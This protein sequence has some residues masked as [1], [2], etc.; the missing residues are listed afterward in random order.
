MCFL[1]P[2]IAAHATT[3]WTPAHQAKRVQQYPKQLPASLPVAH[4]R[5]CTPQW[6]L[7]VCH[8]GPQRRAL[9]RART[10][11][12][13][14]VHVTHANCEQTKHGQCT[15]VRA[16]THTHRSK[17]LLEVSCSALRHMYDK[18]HA[19]HVGGCN[20]RQGAGSK[21]RGL[22]AHTSTMLLLLLYTC[23]QRCCSPNEGHWGDSGI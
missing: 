8:R 18:S 5:V 22:T 4:T 17:L 11:S 21:Q 1:P 12:Q 19:H 10:A 14:R 3:S 2:L 13:L 16:H 15:D 7:S 9:T 23:A 20:T 6:L